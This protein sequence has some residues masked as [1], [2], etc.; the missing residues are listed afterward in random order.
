MLNFGA[1]KILLKKMSKREFAALGVKSSE[2]SPKSTEVPT[3]PSP[4]WISR[5]D[6]LSGRKLDVRMQA[7]VADLIG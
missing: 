6:E 3:D 7:M 1:N 4:K 5:D 2:D